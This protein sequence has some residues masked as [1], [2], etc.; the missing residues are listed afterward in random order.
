MTI[1]LFQCHLCFDEL[2]TVLYELAFHLNLRPLTPGDGE[3]VLTPAHLLFGVTSIQGVV[4]PSTDNNVTVDRMW[5]HRCRVS[6][7][8]INRW[9]SE[10][11]QTLRTWR[12]PRR[13]QPVRLPVVGEVVLVHNEGPRGRW[14]LA[15]IESLI[16]GSDGRCRAATIRMRGRT[17]RRPIAK[18]FSLEAAA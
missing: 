13:G 16:V 15:R 14:P 12:R 17:T 7:H 10:Y 9:T 11:L 4:T 8:L 18:L 2:S 3:N 1:T 6:K 5:R